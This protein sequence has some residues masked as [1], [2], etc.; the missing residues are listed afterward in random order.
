MYYIILSLSLYSFML[1]CFSFSLSIHFTLT[2]RFSVGS[3][4]KTQQQ[5]QG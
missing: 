5:H 4:F 2:F 3:F 1:G